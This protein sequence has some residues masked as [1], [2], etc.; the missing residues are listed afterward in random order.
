MKI[1]YTLAF[2]LFLF[3]GDIYAQINLKD[4][5]EAYHAGIGIYPIGF[6]ELG[7]NVKWNLVITKGNHD[8]YLGFSTH[9]N[10]DTEKW[11][12]TGYAFRGNGV[13]EKFTHYFHPNI[14]Y[15]KYF[16]LVKHYPVFFA[17]NPDF[18]L[19]KTFL[20]TKWYTYAPDYNSSFY[21]NDGRKRV[22]NDDILR[23]GN[24][25]YWQF[26]LNLGIKVDITN[27]IQLNSKAGLGIAHLR[28]EEV[29]D[30]FTEM[31]GYEFP[32]VYSVG[33]NYIFRK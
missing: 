7:H 16:R 10:H 21:T 12:N 30:N 19:G 26:T 28:K 6:Y 18:Q 4:S 17:L 1:K 29:G 22:I 13:A 23:T 32:I 33:V 14:G 31:N 27:Q 8:F 9:I 20:D 11:S 24:F 2:L 3:W 25:R 5:K 15:T